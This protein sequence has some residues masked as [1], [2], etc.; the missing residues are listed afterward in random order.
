[1]PSAAAACR[2]TRRDVPAGTGVRSSAKTLSVGA[3]DLVQVRNQRALEPGGHRDGLREQCRLGDGRAGRPDLDQM[4][5][6]GDRERIGAAFR[7]ERREHQRAVEIDVGHESPQAVNDPDEAAR[8]VLRVRAQEP[9][10][11]RYP[12][13]PPLATRAP[14]QL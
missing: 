1:M 2:T 3:P 12:P 14:A 5:A 6:G 4:V 8:L 10:H 7:L 9:S 13:K 11:P